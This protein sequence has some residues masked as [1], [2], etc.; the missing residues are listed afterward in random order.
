VSLKEPV[1]LGQGFA[2]P[3]SRT[4]QSKGL[5]GSLTDRVCEG[6]YSAKIFDFNLS[7]PPPGAGNVVLLKGF[8]A[9]PMLMLK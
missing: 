4:V 5:T 3:L 1:D 2:A 7:E 8:A 6:D 9:G